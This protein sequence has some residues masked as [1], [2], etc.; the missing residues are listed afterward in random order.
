MT[1]IPTRPGT[2]LLT[3]YPDALDSFEDLAAAASE[4]VF[5]TR[6]NQLAQARNAVQAQLGASPGRTVYTSEGPPDNEVVATLST[7]L[8]GADNDIDY[9]AA[10]AY[11]ADGNEITVEYADPQAASQSLAVTVDGNAI[12]VSLATDGDS[13]ITSTADDIKTE[14]EGTAEAAAL[15]TVADTAA[16]DGSGVVTAMEATVLSGGVDASQRGIAPAGA[17][18][19]DVTNNVQWINGGTQAEPVWAQV[20]PIP[21]HVS[22][23]LASAEAATPVEVLPASS[24]PDGMAAFLEGGT[25]FVSCATDWTDATATKVTIQDTAGTPAVFADVAKAAL[26]GNSVTALVPQSDVT[27]GLPYKRNEG[28][29]NGQGIEIVGDAVFAGGSA[30]V[31]TLWGVIK[32]A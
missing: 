7:N 16:N 17:L 15:V 1:D 28:G 25:L 5:Q 27:F 3:S 20:H 13:L 2:G 22:A 18:L 19:I 23:S 8:T 31:V 10:A 11:G 9:T 32:S 12:T 24:V 21:F 4:D 6:L 26:T 14:I 29:G 30:I